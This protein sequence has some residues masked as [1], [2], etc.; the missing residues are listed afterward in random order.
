M[1]ELAE[2]LYPRGNKGFQINFRG[3]RRALQLVVTLN[4]ISAFC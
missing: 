3:Q 2:I 1:T 4:I